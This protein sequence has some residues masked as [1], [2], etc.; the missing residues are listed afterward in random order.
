MA[1]LECPTMKT[2]YLHSKF[3]SYLVYKLRYMY[4]RF[5]WTPSWISNFRSRCAAYIV[6]SGTLGMPDHENMVFAL[7]I[8]LVS[9]LQHVID[10]L[11]VLAAAIL[12]F[13]TF[14]YIS[15]IL[16]IRNKLN[17]YS[18]LYTQNTCGTTVNK[19]TI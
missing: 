4:L 15:R 13:Q 19:D 3:C 10:V 8:F 14:G 5:R 16:K 18:L 6:Q 7:G 17:L 2:W 1:T 9:G 11:P 12:D